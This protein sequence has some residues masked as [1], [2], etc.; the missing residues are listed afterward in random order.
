MG[1]VR[2]TRG[3]V[4]VRGESVVGRRPERH[5]QARCRTR[6]GGTADLRGS[7]RRGKSRAGSLTAG[8]PSRHRR[9]SGARLRAVPGRQES[10]AVRQARFRAASNNSSRSL[11]RSS[12]IPKCCSSTSPRWAWR[13]ASSIWSSKRSR[14]S[15]TGA[16]D[17]PRRA[18]R[19]AHRRPRGPLAC[20]SSGRLRLTLGPEVGERHGD[21]RQSRTS[22]DA[23]VPRRR[24]ADPSP[25]PWAS[26]RSTRSWP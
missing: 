15:V 18:T 17:P 5:R 6:A 25:M 10:S 12:R 11:G 20:A 8:A 19:A 26:A 21:A 4:R 16:C 2:P 9:G 24:L 7:D 3:D 23:R 22:H 13:R 1:A 14:R